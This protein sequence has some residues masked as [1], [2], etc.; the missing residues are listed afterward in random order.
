MQNVWILLFSNANL[1]IYNSSYNVLKRIPDKVQF[2]VTMNNN[3]FY[4]TR[5]R[6]SSNVQR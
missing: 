6:V 2:I 1:K 5:E 3:T 4:V